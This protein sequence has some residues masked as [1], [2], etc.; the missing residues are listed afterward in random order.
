M[1]LRNTDARGYSS[2]GRARAL[3]ARGTGIETRYL[4]PITI[5]IF[6]ICVLSLISLE[7]RTPRCGRG[8]PGSNPGSGSCNFFIFVIVS[9]DSTRV[10]IAVGDNGYLGTIGA[11][12]S[13]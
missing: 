13:A 11:V 12:G 4:H 7:V 2:I 5:Y 10:L 3:Q 9:R 1:Q 8:N 6:Y